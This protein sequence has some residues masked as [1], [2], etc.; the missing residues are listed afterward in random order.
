MPAGGA[1]R[2]FILAALLEACGSAARQAAAAVVG[3]AAR[4]VG[5]AIKVTPIPVVKK[6]YSGALWWVPKGLLC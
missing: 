5:P 6:G 3:A 4:L 1:G 2:V